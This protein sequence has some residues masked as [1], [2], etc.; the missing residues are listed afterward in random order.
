MRPG[1][2]LF[3]DDG[4]LELYIKQVKTKKLICQALETYSLGARKSINVPGVDLKLPSFTKEDRKDL[5]FI[6]KNDVNWIAASL[7]SQVK[8]IAA[9]RSFLRKNNSKLPIIAKIENAMG[10]KHLDEIICSCEGIMVARGDLGV[11]LPPEEVPIIQH[12]IIEKAKQKGK[13]IIIATQMLESMMKNPRPTRAEATDVYNAGLNHVDAV[14]LSGETATGKHPLK[15]IAMM[16]RILVHTE[17]NRTSNAIQPIEHRGG[18][19]LI[20][21]MSLMLA[22]EAKAKILITL[23]LKGKSPRIVSSYRS[24]VPTVVASVDRDLYLQS[25][26]YY[27]VLPILIKKDNSPQHQLLQVEKKLKSMQLVKKNDTIVIMFTYPT[28]NDSTNSIR[29]WTVQ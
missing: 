29:K 6:V 14:M 21:K 16:S 9:I 1:Q 26:L 24:R 23:S 12:K 27:S 28:T 8:N 17:K 11:E 4:A 15:A 20:C 22:M 18:M 7:V 5:A 25:H 3:I 2:R 13:I 10:V 19:A